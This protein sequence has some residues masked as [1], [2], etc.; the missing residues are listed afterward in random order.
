MNI[1]SH[2]FDY[3]EI[4]FTSMLQNTPFFPEELYRADGWLLRPAG[5][6]FWHR[7]SDVLEA[8]W[9]ST[10]TFM[11]ASTSF[12]FLVS[13]E[14]RLQE[15]FITKLIKLID[16]ILQ[17]LGWYTQMCNHYLPMVRAHYFF[18]FCSHF[19][20]WFRVFLI[21]LYVISQ[22]PISFT[23]ISTGEKEFPNWRTSKISGK[24]V[25]R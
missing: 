9:L 17:K 10:L 4:N 19:L 6:L 5:V 18:C 24:K 12:C 3:L 21:N 20:N 7:T 25:L 16:I 1:V 8:P 14:G 13:N 15:K 2:F 22:D 11:M 23:S